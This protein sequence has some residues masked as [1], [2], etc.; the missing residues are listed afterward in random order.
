MGYYKKKLISHPE[1]LSQTYSWVI[2]RNTRPLPWDTSNKPVV[3]F[4][5][6]TTGT[7]IVSQGR[8]GDGLRFYWFTVSLHFYNQFFWKTKFAGFGNLYKTSF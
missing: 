6:R 5:R 7:L 1:I 2:T 8:L 4:A 3:P